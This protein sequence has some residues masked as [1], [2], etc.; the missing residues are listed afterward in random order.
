MI[1]RRQCAASNESGQPCG[2]PPLTT[3][4]YCLWHDPARTEEAAEARRLG[5]QRRR[6]ETTIAAVYDIEDFDSVYGL[7]RVL[8]IAL[9]DTLALENTVARNRTLIAAITTGAKLLELADHEERLNALEAALGRR[10]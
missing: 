1:L 4:D 9:V 7:S 6:R 5:G 10:V 8:R 2:T 3:S